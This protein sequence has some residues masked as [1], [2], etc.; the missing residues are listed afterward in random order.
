MRSFPRKENW[1]QQYLFTLSVNTASMCR[2]GHFYIFM[3]A[4]R[5][6][7]QALRCTVSTHTRHYGWET[8]THYMCWVIYKKKKNLCAFRI[9]SLIL[10]LLWYIQS[11]ERS[12]GI[13]FIRTPAIYSSP[14]SAVSAVNEHHKCFEVLRAQGAPQMWSCLLEQ[15]IFKSQSPILARFSLAIASC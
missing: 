10:E 15:T 6:A 7:Q 5:N 12:P 14:D 9:K 3:A 13:Q 11:Q 8:K 2:T 1:K 4:L